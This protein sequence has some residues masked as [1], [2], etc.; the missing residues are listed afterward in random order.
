MSCLTYF[1]TS[2]SRDST[3]LRYRVLGL[4]SNL[5]LFSLSHLA[6][7]IL[8]KRLWSCLSRGSNYLGFTLWMSRRFA[9]GEGRA[10]KSAAC[11][12]MSMLRSFTISSTTWSFLSA[13]GVFAFVCFCYL[14]DFCFG[15]GFACLT[16]LFTWSQIHFFIWFAVKPVSL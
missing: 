1:G 13:I 16:L 15:P 12:S 11:L 9:F 5:D 4:S 7:L 6:N 10:I 3:P 8:S 2:I 14:V